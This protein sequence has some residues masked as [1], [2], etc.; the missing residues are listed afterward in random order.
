MLDCSTSPLKALYFAVENPTY[1]LK[2]MA[3]F[4]LFSHTV[5]S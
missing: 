2:E 4:T 3:L 1:D 5:S